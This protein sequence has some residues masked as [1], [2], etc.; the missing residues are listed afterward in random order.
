MA[1]RPIQNSGRVSIPSPACGDG[2]AAK[3]DRPVVFKSP[4]VGRALTRTSL[5]AMFWRNR[6]ADEIAALQKRVQILEDFAFDLVEHLEEFE[7]RPP[8]IARILQ[9][10]E[11]PTRPM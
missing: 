2:P 1:G 5:T 10:W 11:P 7:R 9:Q 4:T 6:Q 3:R 8:R